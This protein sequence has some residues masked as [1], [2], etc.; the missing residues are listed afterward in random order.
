[1]KRG[2]PN[3]PKVLALASLLGIE[4]LH[5][6]G[7]LEALWHWVGAA[8]PT[9]ALGIGV[10]EHLATAIGWPRDSSGLVEALHRSGWLDPHPV[11]SW[12]VHDWADHAPNEVHSALARKGRLFW[13]GAEPS[14]RYLKS[15]ERLRAA[16][17]LAESRRAFHAVENPEGS[18]DGPRTVHDASKDGPREP[19]PLPLNG[20]TTAPPTPRGEGSI[21]A[22]RPTAAWED[23]QALRQDIALLVELGVG[24][25]DAVLVRVTNGSFKTGK[26]RCQPASRLE[27]MTADH[28]L[29]SRRDARA[30]LVAWVQAEGL[31]PQDVARAEARVAQAERRTA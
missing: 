5:A 12:V 16:E 30:M 14:T 7:V 15:D 17:L 21:S 2:T 8:A 10:R 24:A 11:H 26:P 31:E 23:I 19:L 3:H 27:R 25:W 6:V 4:H 28:V 13:D 1:M 20:S 9:G 29:R 18:T 22:E